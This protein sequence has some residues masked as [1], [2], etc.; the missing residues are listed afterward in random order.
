MKDAPK[1]PPGPKPMSSRTRTEPNQPE[2][3]FD[4]R[5]ASL[6]DLAQALDRCRECPLGALATQG[7]PG[8]GP[9]HGARL[10]FV[11]E[12]PGD[13]EDLS[14]EPFVGPA[15]RLLDR[16]FAILGWPRSAVYVTNAVKHFKYALRGKRR[17]HK[18]PAQQEMAA[19]LHWLQSEI[20]AGR[21]SSRSARPPHASSPA[22]LSP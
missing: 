18:T 21:R 22:S 2:P 11:G 12:Q 17:I 20:D 8:A 10:M 1:S 9:E 7:V 3:L 19:C 15:G 14:D 6:D 5:P 16:A 4:E 13:R